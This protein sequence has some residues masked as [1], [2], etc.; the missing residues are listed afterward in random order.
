MIPY[1]NDIA[2]VIDPEAAQ[3]MDQQGYDIKF[4]RPLEPAFRNRASGVWSHQVNGG[5]ILAL[6][7]ETLLAR[8]GVY[9][10]FAAEGRIGEWQEQIHFPERAE[11]VFAMGMQT[12]D[13]DRL[14]PYRKRIS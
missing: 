11:I 8:L 10:R 9:Q 7:Y 13:R 5:C 2:H 3:T 14:E 4:V 12:N 1:D 6:D